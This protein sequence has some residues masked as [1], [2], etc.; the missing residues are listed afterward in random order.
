GV[1]CFFVVGVGGGLF[2]LVFVFF[3]FVFFVFWVFVL[4]L[5]GLFFVF[6]L[7]VLLVLG[8]GRG[9]G[10]GLGGGVGARVA[11]GCVDGGDWVYIWDACPGGARPPR[12]AG[13]GPPAPA[14]PAQPVH[15]LGGVRVD[16]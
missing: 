16:T 2:V 7:G 1:F 11:R 13:T 15:Q 12:S 8:V 9:V 4:F 3:F 5:G 10:G 14:Y 6:G